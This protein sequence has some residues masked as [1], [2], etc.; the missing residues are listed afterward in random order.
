[1]ATAKD[2]ITPA[3]VAAT[4]T[5]NKPPSV[6]VEAPQVQVS[7]PVTVDTAAISKALAPLLDSVRVSLEASLG[8]QRASHE[9]M[10]EAL[11]LLG[12][13]SKELARMKSAP[14]RISGPDRP[15]NF[16]VEFA[17]E[18]GETVGMHIRSKPLN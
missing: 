11:D 7:S 8:A 2:R 5:A 12:D 1:M 18:N 10:K 6:K 16:Y 9:I 15:D 14:I 4:K 3:K 17:E 13:T